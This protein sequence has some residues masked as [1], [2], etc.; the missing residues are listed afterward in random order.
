M[1]RLI[2]FAL[3]YLKTGA[4]RNLAGFFL[5]ILDEAFRFLD[6]VSSFLGDAKETTEYYS[7]NCI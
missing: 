7:P 4:I 3:S 5:R 2:V 1:C 6:E